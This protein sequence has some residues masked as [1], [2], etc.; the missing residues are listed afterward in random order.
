[1]LT[2]TKSKL[3]LLMHNQLEFILS[4]VPGLIGATLKSYQ[5]APR[6]IIVGWLFGLTGFEMKP[7]PKSCMSGSLSRNTS[8]VISLN[9]LQKLPGAY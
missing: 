1:M 4:T 7:Y 9:L 8:R 2:G 5:M 6:P 3:I